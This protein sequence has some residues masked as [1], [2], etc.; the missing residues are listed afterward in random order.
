VF[1]ETRNNNA[2]LRTYIVTHSRI[3]PKHFDLCGKGV[4]QK[5]ARIKIMEKCTFK[6]ALDDASTSQVM[7]SVGKTLRH[8]AGAKRW[9][10][11][12]VD[13]RGNFEIVFR[14]RL[15][16][17]QRLQLLRRPASRQVI[18]GRQVLQSTMNAAF[19]P[20]LDSLVPTARKQVFY[21]TSGPMH[22]CPHRNQKRK[23]GPIRTN[24]PRYPIHQLEGPE[25]PAHEGGQ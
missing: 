6:E 19:S 17:S 4:N 8:H 18:G 5:A 2:A 22:H 15:S 1:S 7:F 16:P 10:G 23:E 24:L 9:I 20:G 12:C 25:S 14:F 21:C 11:P 3:G 13:E